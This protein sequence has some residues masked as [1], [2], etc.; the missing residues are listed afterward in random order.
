MQTFMNWFSGL[1]ILIL[2]VVLFCYGIYNYV[3]NIQ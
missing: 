3:N 1:F 2:A